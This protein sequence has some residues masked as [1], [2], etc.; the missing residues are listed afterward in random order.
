[1]EKSEIKSKLEKAAR[2]YGSHEGYSIIEQA[3][4]GCRPGFDHVWV[5][6]AVKINGNTAEI[7]NVIWDF[8]DF[9][10]ENGE[11]VDDAGNYPWEDEE[12]TDIE[13]E[14]ELDIT[15]DYDLNLLADFI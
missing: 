12:I 10:N 6:K 3:Y 15:D 14:Q 5:A 13:E 9:V 2:E 8:E 4:H 11:D 1:M 7:I